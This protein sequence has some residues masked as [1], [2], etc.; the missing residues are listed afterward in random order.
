LKYL[1]L[2][3]LMLMALG[4]SCDGTITNGDGYGSNRNWSGTYLRIHLLPEQQPLLGEYSSRNPTVIQTHVLWAQQAEIDYFAIAWRGLGSW[5]H[6]TLTDYVLEEPTFAD[7]DWCVLYETPTILGGGPDVS[8]FSLSLASRDTLLHHLLYFHNHFFSRDNY[9]YVDGKPVVYLRQ[10]RKITGDARVALNALRLAYADSTGGEE[11][12][13]VGDEAIWGAVA[14]ADR[15]RIGSMDAI[16]GIDLALLVDHNGYPTGTGFLDDLS[17][18]WQEYATVIS[19]LTEPI[20]LIPTVMPGYN[21]RASSDI[22]RPVIARSLV[23]ST[24]STG[25]TYDWN[26]LIAGDHASNPAMMLLNSFN[27]W[28]RDTQIEIL[29]DNGDIN[30]TLM[31]N[32][33]TAGIRYYP[34][35]NQYIEKTSLNKG[36]VL[37]GAIYEVWYDSQPPG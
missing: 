36:E 20:P 5:G 35:G 2:P 15:N 34:Y 33:K 10:S 22:A 28:Q 24:A 18:L 1:I 16:T 6:E 30:G 14:P 12:F 29:A 26:W 8:S 17:S 37:L 7:I 27:D 13:L 32:T 11:L 31:P 21:D 3:A 25:G 4:M 19:E 9:L 23:A